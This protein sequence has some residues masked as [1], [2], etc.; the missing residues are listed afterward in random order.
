MNS[1]SATDNSTEN[2]LIEEVSSLI[3][4]SAVVGYFAVISETEQNAFTEYVESNVSK[5]NFLDS[6]CQEFPAFEE[7]LKNEMVAVSAEMSSIV[8]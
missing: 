3:F 8:S 6:V 2:M 1:D 5:E 4:E 7:Y